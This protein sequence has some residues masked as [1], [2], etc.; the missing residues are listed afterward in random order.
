[1]YL[2]AA[3]PRRPLMHHILAKILAWG[4]LAAGDSPDVGLQGRSLLSQVR[5]TSISRSACSPEE[6]TV[7][8]T[9]VLRPLLPKKPDARLQFRRTS[10]SSLSFSWEVGAVHAAQ[11]DILGYWVPDCWHTHPCSQTSFKLG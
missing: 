10:F 11:G 1:M 4:A 5:R 9:W 6:A 2:P 8:Q 3:N 7:S